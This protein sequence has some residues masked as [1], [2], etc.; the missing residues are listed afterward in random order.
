MNTR[1]YNARILTLDGGTDVIQGEICIEGDTITYVG[2]G[3]DAPQALL[4]DCEID[5]ENNLILPGFK[6]AHTHSAMTFLRSFA[7]DLPLLEWLNT[8][9]FPMEA[10]LKPEH[11]LWFS[12]LAIMEYLTSGIT[13]NFDMYFFP[14]QIAQASIETGFRTVMVSGL[15]N[16][17]GSVEE[18]EE[19]YLKFNDY[20]D[21]ISYQLGIHAE[22]TC[23]DDLMKSVAQLAYKH[24][25]PVY[26]H[27][28]ETEQEVRECQERHD[29]L[30]PVKYFDSIGMFDYG[31][32]GF[33]CVHMDEEDIE[34]LKA[35]DLYA[36]TNPASNLKLASGICRTADLLA[37]D[38][39]MAIGT[40]GPA[41]NNC[42]DFFREMF[43]VT[44]LGKIREMDAAA[45]P[46]EAVLK[47]AAADGAR[48]MGLHDCDCLAP[49]KKADL[50]M[51]DMK[52][53][54]MQPEHNIVK[55]LVYSGS[56]QN[57]KMTMV[58]G[59]VLYKDGK[60]DIGIDPEEVYAKA[61]EMVRRDF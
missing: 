2:S 1:I 40:D 11:I 37:A 31:G 19:N 32:G 10:H 29:G 48:A 50:I 15:N 52:Q 45:V 36:V 30:G 9:V 22:Y 53:P 13:A 33:H 58:G 43:L 17:G 23:S 25:A 8:R 20:H 7:D 55:N 61:N 57:V 41:S 24:S 27:L 42:L 59:K 5:A 49:G 18:L 44:G 60:F 35:H 34:I 26:M 6:N 4:W 21:L 16:Y 14:E 56:K 3:E 47:M 38:I 51:I 39:P 46:A 54:N 12:K 28:A